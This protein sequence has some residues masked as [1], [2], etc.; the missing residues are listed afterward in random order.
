VEATLGA[1]VIAFAQTC[2][3][4]HYINGGYGGTPGN[5]DGV[6]TNGKRDLR[7]IADDAHLVVKLRETTA[8]LAVNAATLS[9]GKYCVCAGNYNRLVGFVGNPLPQETDPELVAYLDSLKGKPSPLWPNG[10]PNYKEA[11]SPRRAYGPGPNGGDIGGKLVW[12]ETCKGKRHFDCVGF[13]SYCYWKASGIPVQL[14]IAA[15]RQPRA[16]VSKDVYQLKSDWV[17]RN[18]KEEDKPRYEGVKIGLPPGGKLLDGDIIIKAD[19]H[20]GYVNSAGQ[21]FEAQDTDLGVRASGSFNLGS[22]GDWTHLVRVTGSTKGPE[23]KWP[24]GWWRVWDGGLWYYY[25]DPDKTAKSTRKAP[26]NTLRPPADY[27]NSGTWIHTPPETLVILWNKRPD[28]KI[29]TKETFWNAS[30][31]SIH[32][33]AS[34]NQYSPLVANYMI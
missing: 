6:P 19:H 26:T 2:I 21:I 27:V 22:P 1:S 12:G 11:F 30:E 5:D 8:N 15:W 33:N 9:I 4:D 3:G 7:L 34:S 20:I 17:D 29:E 28:A 32:I 16:G 13:I 24:A 14:D 18:L 31:G 25:L 23:L 10:W